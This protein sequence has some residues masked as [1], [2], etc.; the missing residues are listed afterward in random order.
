LIRQFHEEEVIEEED[1]SFIQSKAKVF[2]ISSKAGNVGINLVGANRVII[3]DSHW[4]PTVDLQ[5]LY[6]CYR[7]GQKK[8]VFAYRLIT[9]GTMEEKVYSRSVNKTSLAARVLDQKH[10]ARN[11]SKREL[12]DIMKICKWVQCDRCDKWRMLPPTTDVAELP[13]KWYCYMNVDDK[14]RAVCSAKEMNEKFYHKLFYSQEGTTSG[15][16]SNND[17]DDIDR[18]INIESTAGTEVKEDDVDKVQYT[19]RDGV[20]QKVLALSETS[21]SKTTVEHKIKLE[22][23]SSTS[24]ERKIKSETGSSKTSQDRRHKS[25]ALISRYYFHE[26]L[27]K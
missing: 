27:L 26:S 10:P 18:G 14:P 24:V 2:L 7:Y 22:T 8:P 4:N 17:Q 15:Q 25:V 11:F 23:C 3:F 21:S 16:S 20:L 5:A 13:D 19:K 6:R 12:E 1:I 9:E